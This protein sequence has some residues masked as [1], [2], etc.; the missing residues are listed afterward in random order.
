[1]RLICLPF[2]G[3]GSAPYY[4][5]RSQIPGWID[6][7]PVSLPGHDGRLNE[8]RMTDLRKLVEVLVDD[9]R[10]SL[11]KPFVLLGHSMGAWLAF[12]MARVLRRRGER[13]PEL[14]VV[15]ASRAPHVVLEEPP[16]HSLPET[17]FLDVLTRRYGGI[18]AEISASRELLKLLMPALRAD[19]QMIETYQFIEEPPL[20][21]ELLALGGMEDAAVSPAQLEGW[22]RHTTRGCSVRL[23][24]GGHFFLFDRGRGSGRSAPSVQSSESSAALQIIIDRIE[25]CRRAVLEGGPAPTS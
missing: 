14:L 20:D 6:L 5:W 22:R 1:M 12:E 21:I 24:P 17:E 2:A 11:D 19:L 18:P 15:A 25:K 4:R 8:V 23:L 16:I 7:A 10:P 3:G 13:L 9:M